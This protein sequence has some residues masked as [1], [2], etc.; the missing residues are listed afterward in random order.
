MADSG[1]GCKGNQEQISSQN[2]PP[3]GEKGRTPS[4]TIIR[5]DDGDS[6]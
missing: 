3:K 4:S 1:C 6:K 5:S 2:T